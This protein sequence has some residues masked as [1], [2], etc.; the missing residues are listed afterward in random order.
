MTGDE[1]IAASQEQQGRPGSFRMRFRRLGDL[2]AE[3]GARKN[4]CGLQIRALS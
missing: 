4:L 1:W 2:L 3:G